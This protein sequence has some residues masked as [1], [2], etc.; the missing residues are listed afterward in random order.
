MDATYK[1]NEMTVYK[2]A[3]QLEQ[4]I[5]KDRPFQSEQW[6]CSL[7]E[8]QKK[9]QTRKFRMAVVGEF[10]RGKSSFINA[11][12][13]KRILPEDVLATTATINRIT[14]GEKPK[15]YV[16]MRNE[17]EPVQ[18]ISV[19]DLASYV[20]KLTK[21]REKNASAIREAVVEYPTMLCYNGV[22][23]IDTPGMNDMDDMNQITVNQL[24]DIDLAVVAINAQYPYSDT[25]NRFVIQLLKSRNVCRIIFVIT[26]FDLIR[27]RE[28]KKVLDYLSNRICTKVLDQLNKCHE[29][30][31]GLMEKYHD[32]FD[33][34][35]IYGISSKDAMEALE[36]NDM[37]LYEDS[38]FLRLSKELP[39]V[40]LSSQSLYRMDNFVKILEEIIRAFQK[41][42]AN[43][44]D[45]WKQW[46]AV[47]DELRSTCQEEL[48][49]LF[50]TARCRLN[51]VLKISEERKT[52]IINQI[53]Q[54]LGKITQFTLDDVQK[55]VL[56][57][58][59]QQFNGVNEE[60]KRRLGETVRSLWDD[61]FSFFLCRII[62]KIENGI[63]QYP[64]LYNRIE[65]GIAK[66][67]KLP[68][69]A[70]AELNGIL[71][72]QEPFYWQESPIQIVL[73]TRENQ[74]VLPGIRHVVND[75]A[76]NYEERANRQADNKL[77][78]TIQKIREQLE[79]FFTDFQLIVVNRKEHGA[80]K[81]P[82]RSE[83]DQLSQECKKI[84]ERIQ[85][86]RNQ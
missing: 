31:E 14:Y 74:S 20:T 28:R 1:E 11:L 53:L 27:K 37:E 55:A 35:F 59:Q 8:I 60:N 57:V 50:E 79:L 66:L 46:Q 64:D 44:P 49:Q 39:Q 45:E 69:Q 34:L 71:E 25:E 7:E 24:E 84:R 47:L 41:S 43:E 85:S 82:C 4:M 77:A 18:E 30:Q 5:K 63:N 13:G 54:S 9:I 32:I 33:H 21:A 75:S 6:L 62:G 56:P 61:S 86:S 2:V 15:A 38:G 12:L 80:G 52:E 19:E 51:S 68:E 10:N 29:S 48:A 65:H 83:L 73:Q 26:Y 40:I 72:K 17:N 81:N 22:D 67:K 23:L 76:K 16:I 42:L 3:V 78:Q 36:T 58:M 70:R